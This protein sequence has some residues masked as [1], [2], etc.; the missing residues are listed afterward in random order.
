M[1]L[2]TEKCGQKNNMRF[3]ILGRSKNILL[4]IF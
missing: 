4:C 1:I 2:N 3:E